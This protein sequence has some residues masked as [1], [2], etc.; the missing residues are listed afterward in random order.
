VL[1]GVK[2]TRKQIFLYTLI[3]VAATLILFI[4]PHMMGYFYL[5]SVSILGG[6]MIY[7]TVRLMRDESKN[8]ARTIFW[9]SNCYLAAIF[10]IMVI[11]RIVFV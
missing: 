1:M 9:Y 5:V 6:I 10:A 4:I 2:E 8:W 7:M 3:L 11:D